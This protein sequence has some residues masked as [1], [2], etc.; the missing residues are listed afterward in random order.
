M[1]FNISKILNLD[2]LTSFFS[3]SP[4][5]NN[6]LLALLFTLSAV[7]ALDLISEM[8]AEKDE[9]GVILAV[10]EDCYSDT[11]LSDSAFLNID[12]PLLFNLSLYEIFPLEII[13]KNSVKDRAPPSIS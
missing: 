3:K 7:V 12:R 5:L 6:I 4:S 13:C 2:Y 8:S 11:D 1:K 10:L 9:I